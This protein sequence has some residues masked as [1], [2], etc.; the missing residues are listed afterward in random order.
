M[1][2]KGKSKHEKKCDTQD[3][4][5]KDGKELEDS[6]TAALPGKKGDFMSGLLGFGSAQNSD[7]SSA[8]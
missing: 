1:A 8:N 3:S 7:K 6:E 2:D 4:N 5:K